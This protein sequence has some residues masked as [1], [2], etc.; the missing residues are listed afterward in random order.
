MDNDG[1]GLCPTRCTLKTNGV[2]T[3]SLGRMHELGNNHVRC[4]PKGEDVD[5]TESDWINACMHVVR[6]EHLTLV[7]DR[8][9]NASRLLS[10]LVVVA[11]PSRPLGPVSNFEIHFSFSSSSFPKLF[12]T[13]LRTVELGRT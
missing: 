8:C 1:L 6:G 2:L 12:V 13:S 5:K 3:C 10:P 9:E 7:S 4:R 11:S